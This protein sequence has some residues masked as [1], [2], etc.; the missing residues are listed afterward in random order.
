MKAGY[1]CP[2]YNMI[3]KATIYTLL[4]VICSILPAYGQDGRTAY[5]FLNT[6]TSAHAY[7]LGGTNISII[8]DD[9]FLY[10]QNPALMGPEI[11]MQL[12]F[13]YMRYL[14]GSNYAGVRFG[15]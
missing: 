9:I 10:E 7:G 11:D 6:T 5:N 4:T 13:N 2:P 1:C 12:G 15:K 8:D 3:K 14:V